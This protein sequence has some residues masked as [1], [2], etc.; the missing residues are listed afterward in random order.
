M[1]V[2]RR[3][4]AIAGAV[5]VSV[6]TVG[7]VAWANGELHFYNRFVHALRIRRLQEYFSTWPRQHIAACCEI[8]SNLGR[9]E[10]G[11][12]GQANA[13]A[14]RHPLHGFERT[15]SK[16]ACRVQSVLRHAIQHESEFDID[17]VL[18]E[19]RRMRDGQ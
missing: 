2:M 1:G 3:T 19:L 14:G 15:S 7:G 17:F 6:L 18:L 11:V 9:Y 12:F 13:N 4:P 16:S 10:V 8:A 5:L